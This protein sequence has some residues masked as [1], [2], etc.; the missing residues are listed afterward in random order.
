MMPPAFQLMARSA[1]AQ[2]QVASNAPMQLAGGYPYPGLINKAG[3]GFHKAPKPAQND[4]TDYIRPDFELS[5]R[6]EVLE[7]MP[8]N[9]LKVK[10]NQYGQE[11][12]GYVDAKYVSRMPGKIAE[13]D[14]RPGI[15]Y[16]GKSLADDLTFNDY[17][18]DQITD[19]GLLFHIQVRQSDE[20]NF[21]VMRDMCNDL[22]SSGDLQ[23]NINAM[24]DK[25]QRSE[26]GVYESEILNKAVRQHESTKNF[27]GQIEQQLHEKLKKHGGNAL[28]IP[29]DQLKLKGN[30][31]FGDFG[32]TWRG[33][34]T[35]AINDVWAYDVDITDYDRAGDNYVAHVRLKLYDHFGLDKPDVEKKY[36][37]L[38]G[39]RSW[40][41]LQ[42][43]RGYKPFIVEIPLTY[44]FKGSLKD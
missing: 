42:H 32:D 5:E 4:A 15:G 21:Q 27:V 36:R 9:W 28:A 17:S 2:R 23:T 37:H 1:V 22:F 16:D 3:A 38:A 44:A 31:R 10:R 26:G 8:G 33:G 14:K 13:S 41:V 19:L 35:I 39:F 20:T 24:I 25:F 43:H 30:P 34:L 29:K 6:V 12:I 18:T 11:N 7:M 40:F